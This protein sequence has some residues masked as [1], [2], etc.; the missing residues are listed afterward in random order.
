MNRN[1]KC[2]RREQSKART[3]E[4]KGGSGGTKEEGEVTE[5]PLSSRRRRY[6]H[7]ALLYPRL[8]VI[9]IHEIEG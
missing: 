2:Q 8:V 6:I 1:P 7:A 3:I 5:V 9:T 4:G